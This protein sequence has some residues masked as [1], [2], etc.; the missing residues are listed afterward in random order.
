MKLEPFEGETTVAVVGELAVEGTFEVVPALGNY[1][2][3]FA[4][5]PFFDPSTTQKTIQ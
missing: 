2:L 5:K 3:V 1:Y 4:P